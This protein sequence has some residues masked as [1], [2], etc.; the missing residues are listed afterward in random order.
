MASHL[1]IVLCIGALT[2]CTS[3]Q[4]QPEVQ[5]PAERPAPAGP[6]VAG[7]QAKASGLFKALNADMPTEKYAIT[8]ELVQEALQQKT[9]L[10]GDHGQT[11]GRNAPTVYNAAIHVAQFWDGRAATV[12]EQAT[13]PMMNPVEMAM[14]DAEHVLTVLKSIPGYE[15][16][17]KAA[18]PA[19]ADPITLE[20]VGTAIGA[21]ERTLTTPAPLDRFIAGDRAALSEPQL[22]G[23]QTFLEVGCTTCHLGQGAGGGMF[24]KLGLVKPYET[25]DMGRFVVTGNEADKMFFKVPS[26][27]NIEKTAPY[28]HDG[29]IATLDQAITLMGAHQL[30]KTL[31]PEQVSQIHA[32]LTSMT[33]D[34][35]LDKITP[36]TL[37]E[38]GPN[39]PAA[40]PS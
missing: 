37:P 1:K 5:K 10:F 27:R 8:P 11:G 36:P 34:L 40:D 39:T 4:P 12:E 23:L 7:L 18:F 15:P 26:L 20:N 38:S 31:T 2:A 17:F 16:M 35:P 29:S 32:F 3:P 28:F 25:T 13:G 21:F 6:D 22:T 14:P 24:Q 19:A 33:G 9:L 30:G